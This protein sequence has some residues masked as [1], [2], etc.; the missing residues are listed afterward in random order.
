MSSA[1]ASPSELYGLIYDFLG[2][3]GFT[4]SQTEFVKEA[5]YVSIP[6]VLPC[7]SNLSSQ[8]KKKDNKPFGNATLLDVFQ[9]WK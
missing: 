9:K 7:F 4:K 1:K 8:D 2:H 6:P 5:S 3:N